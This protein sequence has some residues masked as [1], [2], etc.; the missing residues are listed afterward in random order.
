M[1]ARRFICLSGLFLVPLTHQS[2]AFSC[3]S[4]LL[5]APA[6]LILIWLGDEKLS[7]LCRHTQV[8]KV[9]VSVPD[10]LSICALDHRFLEIA[11]TPPC[12]AIL[13]DVTEELL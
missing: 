4:L 3:L 13:E 2:C 11:K 7:M 5:E 6:N 8:L 10:R 9:C 1:H 12:T